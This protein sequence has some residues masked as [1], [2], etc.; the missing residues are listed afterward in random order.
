[1]KKQVYTT[2]TPYTYISGC[3]TLASMQETI[4]E[5]IQRYGPDA[6]WD[7][8]SGWTSLNESVRFK[9]L[10]TDKEYDD[11]IKHEK[12]MAAFKAQRERER[13][14]NERAEYERLQKKY[15]EKK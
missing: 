9:R 15:G 7:F 2:E 3:T 8:D 10:E 1:M 5:L 6:E 14:E 13:E 11:R 12:K 4:A